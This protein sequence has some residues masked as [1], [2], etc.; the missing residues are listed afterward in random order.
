MGG[1]V[2]SEGVQIL[3]HHSEVIGPGVQ[4]LRSIWTGGGGGGGGGGGTISGGSI[5]FVTVQWELS[6]TLTTIATLQLRILGF[7][8]MHARVFL[9]LGF[10]CCKFFIPIYTAV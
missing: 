9:Q 4:I 7:S 5:F 10:S 3:Q 8:K 1:P 6:S 2:I